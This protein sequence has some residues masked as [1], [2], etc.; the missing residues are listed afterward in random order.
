MVEKITLKHKEAYVK[1]ATEFYNSPAVMHPIPQ[2]YILETFD[3]LVSENPYC[4]G[5]VAT[6]KDRVL[7]Y[8]LLAKTYSQEAG[9]IVYWVEEIYVLPEFRGLGV[10]KE[11][12]KFLND[13]FSCARIRLEVE[14]DNFK[15]VNL[16]KK[17]GFE[18]IPY[19]QMIVEKRKNNN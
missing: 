3:L 10:G 9:G 12:F 8:M 19:K 4:L 15:A 14:D 16:Y 6:E 18:F 13:N 17:L 7:G 11:F 1:M 2:S 5:F